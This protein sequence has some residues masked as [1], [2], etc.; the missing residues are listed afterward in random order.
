MI[1]LSRYAELR[2]KEVINI[3]DGSRMGYVCDVEFDLDTGKVEALIMPRKTGFFG[4]FTHHDEYVILWKDIKKI[5]DDII[6]V[7]FCL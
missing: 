4:L 6:F 5:G 2:N 7:E 1:F 3:T